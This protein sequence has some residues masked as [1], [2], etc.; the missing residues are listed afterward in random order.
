MLELSIICGGISISGTIAAKKVVLHHHL[1]VGIA[2]IL[3]SWKTKNTE[4]KNIFRNDNEVI[5]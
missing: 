3:V 2:N 1:N 4:Q 5:S